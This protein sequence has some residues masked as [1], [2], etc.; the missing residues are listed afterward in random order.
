MYM[1]FN[2]T[3]GVLWCPPTCAMPGQPNGRPQGSITLFIKIAQVFQLG[4]T[5]GYREREKTMRSCVF[6]EN[7]DVIHS[8]AFIR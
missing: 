3:F 6:H 7:D 1:L 5:G 8:S 2:S 4:G